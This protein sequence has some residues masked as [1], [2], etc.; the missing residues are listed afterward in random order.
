MTVNEKKK[1][2]TVLTDS[3]FFVLGSLLY[4]VSVKTFTAP[5]QIA[6]GG[7]TGLATVLNYLIGTPIGMLIL[8]LNTPIFLW[9]VWEMGYRLVAKTIAATAIS[10]LAIDLMGLILPVYRGNP[11]LAA[12]FGGVLEGIGLS[13]IFMRGGTTGGTD[14]AARLLGRRFRH[15]SMGK[16]MMGIDAVVVLISAAAF[17]SLESALYAFIAIFVSTRLIDAI[18]YGTDI[19]TGKMIFVVSEKNQEIA[20]LI[21]T[22]LE[23]GVTFLKSKGGYSG[24]EGEVLLCAVRRD[25]VHRV[26]DMIHSV[27]HN[28][29]SI[30]GDAGEISGEGFRERKPEEGTLR[31][32]LR[33]RKGRKRKQK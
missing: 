10:S 13:C 12:I 11:M 32:L 25:E 18:L 7:I 14:M 2:R 3:L 22:E 5:N 21:M 27:D 1:T 19:G 8:L 26:Q 16:L 15:I 4:S 20:N 31:D 33:K 30:V 17:Q 24:R 9:A 29:F 23:R 28:A 6:P